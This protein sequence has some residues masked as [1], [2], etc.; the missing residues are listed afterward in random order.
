MNKEI[1]S[2]TCCGKVRKLAFDLASE[3]DRQLSVHTPETL[4]V[5][6]A[7][8]ATLRAASGCDGISHRGIK[9]APPGK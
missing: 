7:K 5:G 3:L 8:W 9:I 6:H 4:Y 1:T 2:L